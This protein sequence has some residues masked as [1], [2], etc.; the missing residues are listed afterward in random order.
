MRIKTTFVA[1]RLDY[2]RL[3]IIVLILDWEVRRIYGKDLGKLSSHNFWYQ[4]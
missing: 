3:D 2:I 4:Y 1:D